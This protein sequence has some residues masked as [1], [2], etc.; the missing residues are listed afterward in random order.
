MYSKILSCLFITMLLSMPLQ[1]APSDSVKGIYTGEKQC[2]K[3]FPGSFELGLSNKCYS[4]PTGYKHAL[5]RKIKSD[6]V[7]YKKLAGPFA[8]AQYKG[9]EGCQKGSAEYIPTGKC[10]TCP[11]G[12]KR[13]LNPGNPANAKVCSI[14]KAALRKKYNASKKDG[15]AAINF[16]LKRVPASG[17]TPTAAELSTRYRGRNADIPPT[18]DA[19]VTQYEGDRERINYMERVLDGFAEHNQ[20]HGTHYQTVSYVKTSGL[21]VGVGYAKEW[22]FSMTA[23]ADGTKQCR[24]LES[25]VWSGGIQ[26]DFDVAEGVGIHQY[27]IADIAGHANGFT[28]AVAWI[29]SVFSWTTSGQPAIG[30]YWPSLTHADGAMRGDGGIITSLGLSVAYAHSNT[31]QNATPVPCDVLV[32]GPDFD[33]VSQYSWVEESK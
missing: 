29:D 33:K 20:K 23:N 22:G 18:P 11:K 5:W 16:L 28:S 21:A 31:T 25:K 6:K 12:Y 14:D 24:K 19:G 10:Y 4:C 2:G 30:V 15:L 1:A 9:R 3:K 8:K 27:P 32:W 17:A 26:I 13:N 7:C